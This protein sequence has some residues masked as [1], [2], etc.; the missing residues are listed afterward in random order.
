MIVVG[1]AFLVFASLVEFFGMEATV[2]AFVTGGLFILL[3]LVL[4][5]RLPVRR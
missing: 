2:A 3:G 1:A 4:G 5:E